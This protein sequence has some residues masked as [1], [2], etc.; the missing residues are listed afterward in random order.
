MVANSA[1]LLGLTSAL[2]VEPV[3][4][5]PFASAYRNFYRA[6]INGLDASL[7]WPGREET[8]A[9]DLVKDLL[10]VAAA[11]LDR[12]GV[13][14]G[15]SGRML[16]IVQERVTRRRTGSVWQR[17]ALA[18]AG[19]DAARMVARYRELALTGEPVHTWPR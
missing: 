1:F 15:E 6:A 18:A 19:G 12:V 7:A 11:G 14:S 10:P 5:F 16:E 3:E 2:A 4:E 17:E 13:E 9:A 8:P